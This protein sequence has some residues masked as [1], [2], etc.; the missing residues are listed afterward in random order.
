M[1]ENFPPF[2]ALFCLFLRD[3]LEVC[4]KP[5]FQ[6][7]RSHKLRNSTGGVKFETPCSA[8]VI[9]VCGSEMIRALN[10]AL[11]PGAQSWDEGR[12]G[13]TELPL[14]R[15]TV[16]TCNPAVMPPLRWVTPSKRMQLLPCPPLSHARFS[17]YRE[18]VCTG[19]CQRESSSHWRDVTSGRRRGDG[20]LL[21]FSETPRNPRSVL[22]S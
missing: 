19:C 2:F 16:L 11:F 20:V 4:M 1:C 6:P 18:H 12:C 15:F 21:L 13:E 22:S 5:W 14:P 17:G 10:N 7:W 3:I 9:P 8:D